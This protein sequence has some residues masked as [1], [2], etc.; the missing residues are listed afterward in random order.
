MKKQVGIGGE[1]HQQESRKV[2]EVVVRAAMLFGLEMVA[3][4]RRQEAEPQVAEM[5]D[6]ELLLWETRMDRMRK[7]FI[8]GTAHARCFG[9]KAR[10]GRLRRCGP[11]QRRDSRRM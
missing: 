8:K 10:Q 3:L 7:K 2:Y 6:V 11:V 1:K 9:G 5:R 4:R